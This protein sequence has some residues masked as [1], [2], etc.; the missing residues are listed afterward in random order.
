MVFSGEPSVHGLGDGPFNVEVGL[1][2]FLKDVSVTL[3]RDEASGRPR[4]NKP[5][6]VKDKEQRPLIKLVK[7]NMLS[8]KRI[9]KNFYLGINESINDLLAIFIVSVT[10]FKYFTIL[11]D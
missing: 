9:P 10:I 7:D 2:L 1:N 8:N 11:T 4:I 5:N 3:R 6:S